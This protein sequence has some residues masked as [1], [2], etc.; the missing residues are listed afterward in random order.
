MKIINIT[1]LRIRVTGFFPREEQVEFEV[2]F[3]DG[4]QK[5]FHKTAKI[6]DHKSIVNRIFLEIKT[7]ENSAYKEFD[8]ETLTANS[9]K[10]IFQ[11]EK[12]ARKALEVFFI[13][14]IGRIAMVKNI[15][16]AEGYMDAI[17][18]VRSMRLEF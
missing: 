2:S 14:L 11:N 16:I 9:L 8:G 6:T 17:R 4:K 7:M 18:C 5:Q 3:D 10:I 12:S 13:E 1:L 15:K